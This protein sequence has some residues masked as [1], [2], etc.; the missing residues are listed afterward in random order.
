[1]PT[2]AAEFADR[3]RRREYG[4]HSSDDEED[5]A[6]DFG[7]R[8]ASDEEGDE[9]SPVGQCRPVSPGR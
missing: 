2:A 6:E 4:A 7:S 9:S 1:M 5:D 3:E 8:S